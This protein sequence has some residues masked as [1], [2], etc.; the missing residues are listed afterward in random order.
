M[1][2]IVNIVRLLSLVNSRVMLM[3]P[4]LVGI[5][6]IAEMLGISRQRVHAIVRT[7]EEFPTAVAD[8]S[9]GT[10]WIRDEVVEW[11]IRDGRQSKKHG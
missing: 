2:T 6:E 8:L 7:H 5:A 9:A 4:E 11:A 1:L 10:I 3:I